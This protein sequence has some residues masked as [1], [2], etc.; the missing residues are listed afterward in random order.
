MRSCTVKFVSILAGFCIFIIIFNYSER[1]FP[2]QTTCWVDPVT[3]SRKTQTYKLFIFKTENS[4][5]QSDL[6]KW[7]LKKYKTYNNTWIIISGKTTFFGMSTISCWDRPAI[8]SLNSDTMQYYV[9]TQLDNELDLFI[10]T[11]H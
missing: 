7:Y 1:I 8:C 2:I 11:I 10:N 6:E 4:I 3:G 5:Y 9:N